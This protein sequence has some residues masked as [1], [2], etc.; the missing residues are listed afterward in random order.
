VDPKTGTLRPTMAS[1]DFN[2]GAL[3]FFQRPSE[4]WTAGFFLHYDLN[5][6]ASVYSEFMFMRNQT[7]GGEAPGGDFANNALSLNCGA[8]GVGLPGN[9]LITAQERSVSALRRCWP[10]SRGRRPPMLCRTT[11]NDA[12]SKAASA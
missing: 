7:T 2:F 10:H 12:T 3:N 5:E 6:H 1:D 11:S 4:R 9:P 8:V